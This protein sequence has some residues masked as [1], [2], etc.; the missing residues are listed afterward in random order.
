VAELKI[1]K[2]YKKQGWEGTEAI[3]TLCGKA[4]WFKPSIGWKRL[5]CAHKIWNLGLS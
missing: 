4:K 2:L 1:N 3:L 5:P